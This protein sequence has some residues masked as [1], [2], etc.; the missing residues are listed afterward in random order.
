MAKPWSACE[1]FRSYF[2]LVAVVEESEVL[3]GEACDGSVPGAGND[4]YF[5]ELRG[6]VERGLGRLLRSGS[7]CEGEQQG[8]G[9]SHSFPGSSTFSLKLLLLSHMS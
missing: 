2:L 9:P 4:V 3:F 6:C 5:N 1:V 8:D 7:E